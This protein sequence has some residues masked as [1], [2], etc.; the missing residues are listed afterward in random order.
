M[1]KR[2]NDVLYLHHFRP[3]EFGKTDFRMTD[4]W[5]LMCPRLLVLTDTFRFQ[6]DRRVRISNNDFALGRFLG[7][8]SDSQHNVDQWGEVRALDCFPEGMDTRKDAEYAVSLATEL[9]FTGIGLYPHWNGGPGLHLDTRRDREP[10]NP[11]IWGA[12]ND[13]Q[14]NQTY[15]SL[16]VALLAM[17]EKPTDTGNT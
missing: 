12:V 6:W 4:W 3:Y 2:N 16:E 13:A 7:E 1:K 17:S 15:C 5:H 10:G 14:G 9:G 8:D 11:A